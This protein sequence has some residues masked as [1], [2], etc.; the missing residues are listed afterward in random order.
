MHYYDND[1]LKTC[2]QIYATFTLMIKT[3]RL[4]VEVDMDETSQV[5]KIDRNLFNLGVLK[6]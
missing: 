4:V 2:N 6:S 1:M 3:G 5:I